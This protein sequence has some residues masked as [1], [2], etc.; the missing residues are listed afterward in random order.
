MMHSKA[1]QFKIK[2]ELIS[3]YSS[4]IGCLMKLYKGSQQLF[5][6]LWNMYHKNLLYV[7]SFVL[8]VTF[9]A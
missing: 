9:F 1:K 5:N 8:Y 6:L 7:T 3:S 4:Q 2:I